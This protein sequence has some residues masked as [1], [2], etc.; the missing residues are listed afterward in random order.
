MADLTDLERGIERLLMRVTGEPQRSDLAFVADECAKLQE[1]NDRLTRTIKAMRC[2]GEAPKVCMW[3]NEETT[4]LDAEGIVDHI[5]TCKTSP[6]A[7]Q[8]QRIEELQESMSSI[9]H[10]LYTEGLTDE[11]AVQAVGYAFDRIK[12]D[13]DLIAEVQAAQVPEPKEVER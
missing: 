8:E 9:H 11:E 4:G 2:G 10:I 6:Y 7:R 1:H 12:S 3:C 13:V 5:M